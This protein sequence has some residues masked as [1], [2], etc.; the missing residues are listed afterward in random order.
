L[1]GVLLCST[2]AVMLGCTHIPDQWHETGPAASADWNSPT[3]DDV[4]AHFASAEQRHRDWPPAPVVVESGAVTHWPLYFEDPFVAK[5]DGHTGRNKYHEG[6]EDWFAT[7]YG[8]SRHTLNWLFFGASVAVTPPW[9]VMESDGRVSRQILGYDHDATQW[10]AA[11]T[12]A[13]PDDD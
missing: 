5:G 6:W 12:A 7:L 2:P 3:A 4:L 9:T 1:R 13:A 10:H 11:P 8:Y